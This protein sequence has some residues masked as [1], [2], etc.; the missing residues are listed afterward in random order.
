MANRAAERRTMLVV[1]DDKF[2]C[3]AVRDALAT[4]VLHIIVAHTLV[5]AR[6]LA[7]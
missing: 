1:D 4:E 2:L 6:D 7:R 3:D 5:D